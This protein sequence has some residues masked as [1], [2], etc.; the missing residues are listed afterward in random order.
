MCGVAI[1]PRLHCQPV[2]SFLVLLVGLGHYSVSPGD[3]GGG[4][5]PSA[6]ILGGGGGGA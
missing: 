6:G 4:G 2:D 5:G 1:A 3:G